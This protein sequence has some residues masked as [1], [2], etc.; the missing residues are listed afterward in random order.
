[1]GR[2]TH[3]M[4]SPRTPAT[5]R[6]AVFL[7]FYEIVTGVPTLIARILIILAGKVLVA[8]E[9][10]GRSVEIVRKY[11]ISEQTQA[12]GTAPRTAHVTVEAFK[13]TPEVNPA[14]TRFGCSTSEAS[15]ANKPVIECEHRRSRKF[16]SAHVT[17][18]T[19][20]AD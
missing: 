19:V 4:I 16:A 5:V 2:P 9:A 7:A 17:L 3:R 12:T 15:R 10:D 20:R 14:L 11:R 13:I 8:G 1:M 18:S 6:A